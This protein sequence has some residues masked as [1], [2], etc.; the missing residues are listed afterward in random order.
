MLSF[1]VQR[2]LL[3]ATVLSRYKKAIVGCA[4]LFRPMYAEA[5]MGHPSREEGFVVCSIAATPANSTKLAT[6]SAF[7]TR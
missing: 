5:N 7:L 6:Q 2:H 4:H 3:L 1:R